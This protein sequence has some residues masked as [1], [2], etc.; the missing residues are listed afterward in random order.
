MRSGELDSLMA[1]QP[2]EPIYE[3]SANWTSAAF[4]S[5]R[6]R[7]VNEMSQ[8]DQKVDLFP[9][10]GLEWLEALEDWVTQQAL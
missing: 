4:E 7:H 3:E 2:Y 9:S 8:S 6:L 10:K 5:L 1:M